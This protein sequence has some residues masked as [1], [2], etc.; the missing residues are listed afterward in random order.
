MKFDQ[1]QQG[2]GWVAVSTMSRTDT[3]IDDRNKTAFDW[4]KDG[5]VPQLLQYLEETK[6]NINNQD[7]NV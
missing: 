7:D 6:T 5:D 1:R 4:C 3:E 2:D